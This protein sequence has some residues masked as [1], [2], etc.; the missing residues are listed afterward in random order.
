M[1]RFLSQSPKRREAAFANQQ[2]YFDAITESSV[3]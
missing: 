3:H 1:S 2:A